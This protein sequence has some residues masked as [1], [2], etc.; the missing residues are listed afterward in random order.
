M[1]KKTRTRF[2][3]QCE[4]KPRL[5]VEE[6]IM[7]EEFDATKDKPWFGNSMG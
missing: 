6:G 4:E 1:L 7:L 5:V 3:K 2:V